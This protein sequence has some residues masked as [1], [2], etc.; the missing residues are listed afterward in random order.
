M[1]KRLTVCDTCWDI[2]H[3]PL[4]HVGSREMSISLRIAFKN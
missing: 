4:V 2:T 1:V 3:V